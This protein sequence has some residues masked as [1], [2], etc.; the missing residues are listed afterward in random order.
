MQK[1]Q[2]LFENS[3]WLVLPCFVVGVLYA[4][5]L[6]LRGKKL[7]NASWGST[8]NY[9]LAGLRF[10]LVSL[11]C[12]L[13]IGPFIKQINSTIED[14]IVVFAI[15]NS[16]SVVAV[17]DSST[18]SQWVQQVE[19]LQQ[20]LQ[21]EDF[22]VETRSLVATEPLEAIKF[23]HTSSDIDGLLKSIESEYEGRNLSSVVLI[24]D[25]IYNEGISSNLF[26]L[27]V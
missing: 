11:L 17:E 14:P 7:G 24:S 2:L 22:Q 27:P 25:G 21:N 13:I 10:F 5:L 26:S 8:I 15:D 9:I 12:L 1:I 18:Q 23:N 3:P 20:K 6:Y 4:L 16:A 19:S